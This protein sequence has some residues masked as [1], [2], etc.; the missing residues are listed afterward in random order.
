VANQLAQQQSGGDDDSDDDSDG[1]SDGDSDS[2][3]LYLCYQRLRSASLTL[4]S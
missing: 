4:R 3:A 1:D 2:V